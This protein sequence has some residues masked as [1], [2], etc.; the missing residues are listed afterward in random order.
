MNSKRNQHTSQERKAENKGFPSN[1]LT[2][3]EEKIEKYLAENIALTKLDGFR[4][5]M[6]IIADRVDCYRETASD[7]TSRL[8][9]RGLF[10]KRCSRLSRTMSTPNTFTFGSIAATH[11]MIDKYPNVCWAINQDFNAQMLKERSRSYLLTQ[12]YNNEYMYRNTLSKTPDFDLRDYRP[13]GRGSLDNPPGPVPSRVSN[14]FA[15]KENKMGNI[16]LFNQKVSAELGITN[17]GSLLLSAFPDEVLATAVVELRRSLANRS[18]VI[19]NAVSWLFIRCKSAC[20]SRQITP[21]YQQMFAEVQAAG[22]K[23]GDRLLLQADKDAQFRYDEPRE[24]GDKKK[25]P[26]KGN[27]VNN[28]FLDMFGVPAWAKENDKENYVR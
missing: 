14:S 23:P 4:C 5:R 12:N 6:R 17:Y 2:P 7:L 19:N 1:R 24:K 28:S 27:V 20:E 26:K 22:Y 9:E 11:S 21:Y 18:K 15:R 10:K 13:A 3:T 25:F 16:T 8:Q